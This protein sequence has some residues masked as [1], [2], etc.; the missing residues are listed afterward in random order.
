MAAAGISVLVICVS[1]LLNTKSG[2][3]ASGWL[4]A[5]ASGICIG[6]YHRRGSSAEPESP[7]R[8]ESGELGLISCKIPLGDKSFRVRYSAI[9]GN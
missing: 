8:M 3:H 9:T 4:W 6:H 5:S 7:E 2:R 1:V